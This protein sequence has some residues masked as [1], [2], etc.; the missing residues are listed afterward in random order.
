MKR[1]L[2]KVRKPIFYYMKM[3]I[4]SFEKEIVKVVSFIS[5][6]PPL[7]KKAKIQVIV[8]MSDYIPDQYQHY[9]K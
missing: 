6:V 4:I 8:K 2:F 5:L 1:F 3:S 9:Y 7:Q